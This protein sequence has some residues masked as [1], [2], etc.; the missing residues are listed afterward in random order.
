MTTAQVAA[1]KSLLQRTT[2]SVLY[3]K[4]WES[5]RNPS[6]GTEFRRADYK[7]DPPWTLVLDSVDIANVE[8]FE[9]GW[10]RGED[11]PAPPA[12]PTPERRGLKA[13]WDRYRGVG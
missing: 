1:Y 9:Q 4:Q 10:L 8:F 5:W 2:R 7:M 12:A 11:G 13:K 3:I 6:D